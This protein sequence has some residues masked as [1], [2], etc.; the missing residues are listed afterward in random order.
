LRILLF[1]SQIPN[2]QSRIELAETAGLEPAREILDGLANRYGYRF[3]TFPLKKN[4]FGRQ[5]MKRQVTE[6][7]LPGGQIAGIEPATF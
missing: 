3:I 2:P 7:N 4:C 1:Q 5:I 6:L